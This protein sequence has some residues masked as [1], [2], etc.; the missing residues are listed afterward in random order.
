MVLL[1]LGINGWMLPGAELGIRYYIYPDFSKLKDYQVWT[2]AAGRT[3]L[4][5]QCVVSSQNF[6]IYSLNQVQIFFT[7]SVS[8]GGM[9]ALSSYNKFHTNIYR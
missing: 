4:L 2:D 6:F 7:L 5:S 3:P 8:Y 9:I 1:I